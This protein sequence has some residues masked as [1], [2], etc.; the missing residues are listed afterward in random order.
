MEMSTS[1]PTGDERPLATASRLPARDGLEQNIR[2]A[3]RTI[4]GS[5]KAQ[6][7]EIENQLGITGAQFWVLAELGKQP[8]LRVSDLA[9]LICI[10]NS[11]ASNLLDKLERR[12]LIQRERTDQD[13]RVVRLKLTPAGT[14]LLARAPQPVRSVVADALSAISTETLGALD[15]NLNELVARLKVKDS[16]SLLTPLSEI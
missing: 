13:Q 1:S 10:H 3:L 16:S 8:G 9:R 15:R 2:M 6:S 11:T 12:G 14:E 5:A 4:F 7:R